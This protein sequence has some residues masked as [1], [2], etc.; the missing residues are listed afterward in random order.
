MD[1]PGRIDRLVLVVDVCQPDFLVNCCVARTGLDQVGTKARPPPARGRSGQ[2]VF[3]VSFV[4][5]QG[6]SR[7]PEAV[8]KLPLCVGRPSRS[9]LSA[10]VIFFIFLHDPADWNTNGSRRRD[11]SIDFTLESW[12]AHQIF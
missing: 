9:D 1:T 3:D 8:V 5:H 10:A 2:H 6:S 4:S 11:E 7:R 12:P